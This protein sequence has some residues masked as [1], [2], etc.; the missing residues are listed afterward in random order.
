MVGI[1]VVTMATLRLRRSK[2]AV[3]TAWIVLMMAFFALTQWSIPFM[4]EG[5][6]ELVKHLFL[7]DVL[8]DALLVAVV[9]YGIW[10]IERLVRAWMRLRHYS[11]G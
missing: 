8:F 3:L 6:N 4:G 11:N 1:V 2:K 7:Y 5:E 10:Q 9:G